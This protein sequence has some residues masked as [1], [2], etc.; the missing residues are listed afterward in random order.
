MLKTD[1]NDYITLAQGMLRRL[2]QTKNPM[3][4]KTNLALLCTAVCAVMLAFSQNAG[5]LTV[6]CPTSTLPS[7]TTTK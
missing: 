6:P 5:A 1:F 2:Y 3:K 7:A 4:I